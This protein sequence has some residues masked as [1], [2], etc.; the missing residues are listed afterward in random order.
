[1]LVAGEAALN[2][3][4][5]R[6]VGQGGG[7]EHHPV[8]VGLRVAP[9]VEVQ[10]AHH[11]LET[12]GD[13]RVAAYAVG[14]HIVETVHPV[15]AHADGGEAVCPVNVLV[16]EVLD[17]A[18]NVKVVLSV[19][20]RRVVNTQET[21]DGDVRQSGLPWLLL[22]HLVARVDAGK[23]PKSVV[24]I[25]GGRAVAVA[26][27]GGLKVQVARINLVELFGTICFHYR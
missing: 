15:A 25:V 27:A 21:Y 19:D 2:A 13:V 22:E 4:V 9:R 6:A 18:V 5:Q 26:A 10:G 20:G 14:V 24:L 11:P 16:V 17:G 1:M 23:H 12:V 8:G 3:E 7:V